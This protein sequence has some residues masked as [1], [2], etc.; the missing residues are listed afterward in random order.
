MSRRIASFV[1]TVCCV[2][3]VTGACG[4]GGRA[5]PGRNASAVSNASASS[6]GGSTTTSAAPSSAGASGQPPATGVR[7]SS[8]RTTSSTFAAKNV[9]AM[10][11]SF[12]VSVGKA[13]VHPEDTQSF[14]VHGGLP[15]QLLIYDT[16]YANGTD[17]R[18]SHYGTGSGHGKFDSHGSFSLSFV[19][20]GKVPPGKTYLSVASSYGSQI[21]QART[22]FLI[23]PL[24]QPCP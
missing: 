7:S 2:A 23:K 6:S 1:A 5:Q 24:T 14:T 4:G 15:N 20:A 11:S 3:V 9:V 19:L 8:P 17:D 16:E 13:C 12:K 18:T 21:V 22:T 10:P